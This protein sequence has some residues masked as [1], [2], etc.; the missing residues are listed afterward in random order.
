MKSD[1]AEMALD[2]KDI[3]GL[4]RLIFYKFLKIFS[5]III[6]ITIL[7]FYNL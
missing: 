2:E 1:D 6:D 7:A 5:K 3:K 4:W